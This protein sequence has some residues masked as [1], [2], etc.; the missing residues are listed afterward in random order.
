MIRP[1]SLDAASN[2]VG[3]VLRWFV[4]CSCCGAPIQPTSTSCPCGLS[5][6]DFFTFASQIYRERT[7]AHPTPYLLPALYGGELRADE[8]YEALFILQDPSKSYTANSWKACK[9]VQEAIVR[10]RS[11]FR[12]WAFEPESHQAILFSKFNMQPARRK[13][14]RSFYERFYVTD[15]WKD[16]Q[17]E[18]YWRRK[19]QIELREVKARLVLFIGSEAS[20][21]G[22]RLLD[23]AD[24]ERMIDRIDHPGVRRYGTT[25]E[26]YRKQ[27]DE[28]WRRIT[29]KG[30]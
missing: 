24:H 5:A 16:G 22:R 20:G 27:V 13:R 12:S 11:I 15:V 19:L 26:D 14:R 7:A 1:K 30:Y 4:L 18:E 6:F 8:S 28:L 17:R 10:H 3:V 23:D 9:T 29:A 21:E 25:T 2:G